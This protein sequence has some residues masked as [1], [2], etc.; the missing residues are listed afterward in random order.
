[1]VDELTEVENSIIDAK[2]AIQEFDNAILALHTE[3]FNRIQ[4]QFA[5]F[6]SE[7]SN[8]EGLFSDAD[9][10]DGNGNWTDEALARLGLLAQ[11][12]EISTY[13]ISSY[14]KQIQKLNQDYLDGKYSATEYADRLA[15]LTQQQWD[16]VNAT[17]EAKNSIY[18][19]NEIRIN[20]EIETINEEIQAYRDLV[21][22][23]IEA[24]N[25]EKDLHDY[26]KSIEQTTKSKIAIERQ[27]AALANDDSAS[28][29]AQRAKLQAELAEVNEELEEKQYE[30]SIKTQQEALEQQFEAYETERQ[31]EITALEDSLKEKEALIRASFETVKQNAEEIG[32]QIT[33]KA[34]QHGIEMSASLTNAW[35]SGENAIASYGSTLNAGAS[36][37]IVDIMNV[38][39]QT[40]QLQEQAN[41]TAIGLANMFATK[42]DNLVA[43]LQAS[44]TNEANLNQMTNALRDSLINTLERGYNISSIT[45]GLDAIA[46]SAKN[47]ENAANS[48][49]SALAK[50]ANANA[51]TNSN[52]VNDN[53]PQK[54]GIGNH[55]GHGSANKTKH[56]QMVMADGG[57]VSKNH[58][59]ILDPIAEAVGEDTVVNVKRG[60]RIL[61]SRQ[62]EAFE[63]LIKHL[64]NPNRE[65][66]LV[67]MDRAR[68]NGEFIMPISSNWEIPM[69]DY[70]DIK[71]NSNLKNNVNM[72]YGSLVTINGNVNDTNH[73]IKGMEKV[74]Q[75]AIEKSWRQ[76]NNQMKYGIVY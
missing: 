55:T 35:K 44:Y 71:P 38:E 57:V 50:M 53:S 8:M 69:R 3:I 37:F 58:K 74:A 25:A 73:F 7:L 62:N 68:K 70:S 24:L 40:W 9:V 6:H 39:T 52:A 65:M 29:K 5:N 43:Q 14:D 76:L 67:E 66:S 2:T 51:N 64:E 49:S 47:V 54:T 30:N 22:S 56:V 42:A 21:D 4:E 1:M 11:Q 32:N 48:A 20:E 60:E 10:S 34:N 13:Q 31:E 61:T 27:L 19:L 36:Q 63:K 46:N 23:Q 16:A 26:R 28:A 45:S 72:N 75:N 17:E 59:S 33:S 12:Y 15:E 18:E 41:Q